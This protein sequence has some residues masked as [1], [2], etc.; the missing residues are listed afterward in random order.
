MGDIVDSNEE[1]KKHAVPD[2]HFRN[3]EVTSK[4]MQDIEILHHKKNSGRHSFKRRTVMSLIVSSVLLVSLTAYAATGHIQIL[5]TKG[6]VVVK[7]IDVP[8][9]MPLKWSNQVEEYRKRVLGTLMPGELAAYY[10]KDDYINKINGYDTVNPIK[11]EYLPVD[12]HSYEDFQREQDRTSAPFLKKPEYLPKDVSF[13]YGQI[14]PIG[15]LPFGNEKRKY[16]QLKQSLVD[17]ADSS[18]TED[19]LFIEKLDWTKASS[20]LLYLSSGKNSTAISIVA[21]YG[22][23]L[24]LT[25]EMNATSEK[26]QLKNVEAIYLN[27]ES[28]GDVIAW[29]DSKLS[30][31]YTIMVNEED[32]LSKKELLK[33]AE[34]MIANEF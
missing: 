1:L 6:E 4:V 28:G 24:S 15:P 32:V 20:T 12:Y 16:D 13:S 10:I 9:S 34:S 14:T 7:T 19:P 33:M 5:N 27:K 17:K 25:Q 30:V 26:I 23:K 22:S 21:S 3:I 8:T 29:Y 31:A 2:H 11:Y 18:K